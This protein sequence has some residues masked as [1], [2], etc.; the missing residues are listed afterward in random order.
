MQH[1]PSDTT[2]AELKQAKRLPYPVPMDGMLDRWIGC[3][4]SRIEVSAVLGPPH[5]TEWTDGAGME[6][7]WAYE[8]PCGLKLSYQFSHTT[9]HGII[10]LD[11]PEIEHAVRH[12]PLRREYLYLPDAACY[13]EMIQTYLKSYPHRA[14]ELEQLKA[15]QVW[16]IDDNGN[17][18][19]VGEPTSERDALCLVEQYE[20][21]GHKQMY[22]V[23]PAK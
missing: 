4:R 2:L 1:W 14:Q 19:A 6:D 12:L 5:L 11:T 15:F 22:W 8:Y 13:G 23:T 21:R 20:A 18:F 10:V 3:S 17:V 16:R 7:F 9:P